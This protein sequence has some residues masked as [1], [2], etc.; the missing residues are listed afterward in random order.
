MKT[1]LR[2]ETDGGA[3]LG[4]GGLFFAIAGSGGGFE[5]VQQAGGRGGNFL[6]R[7]E[8]GGLVGLRRLVEA[9]DLA[10]ELQRSG[11]DFLVGDRRIE[12]EEN[13]DVAAHGM[14]LLS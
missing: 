2:S 8:K 6:Y 3:G 14:N 4:F 11:V 9:A 12:V 5:R 13:F 7:G 1:V 10:H